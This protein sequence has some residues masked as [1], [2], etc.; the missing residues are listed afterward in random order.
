[1]AC[2]FE[3]AIQHRK[4]MTSSYF[5]GQHFDPIEKLLDIRTNPQERHGKPGSRRRMV[6]HV[7]PRKPSVE[8]SEDGGQQPRM[9]FSDEECCVP[10]FCKNFL[11]PLACEEDA[12]TGRSPNCGASGSIVSAA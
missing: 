4:L 12:V 5:N 6:T 7:M 11:C 2:K 8:E 10:K 3:K 9:G 1:M